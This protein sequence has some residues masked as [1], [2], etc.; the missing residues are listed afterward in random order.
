MPFVA[1]LIAFGRKLGQPVGPRKS[2]PS[3]FASQMPIQRQ[4]WIGIGWSRPHDFMKASFCSFVIRG[5][6]AN[7]AWGP[8][9]ASCRMT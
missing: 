8:P 3:P 6:L 2:K 1:P 7:F 4:Y 5:L 9:G